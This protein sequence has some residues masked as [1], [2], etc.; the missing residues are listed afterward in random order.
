MGHDGKT[1][2]ERCKAKRGKLPGLAFAEKI[3]WR[4]RPV[5]GNLSKLTCLWE[6]GIFLGVKG[7]SGECIVGDGNGVWKTRT[8][9]R[10]PLEERWDKGALGLVG[11]VPWRVNDDDP[12]AD[13][14]AM[15]MDIPSE[16]RQATEQEREE[17]AQAPIPRNFYITKEHLTKYGDSQ[18][19]PGC[20][21]SLRVTTRQ[22]HNTACRRRFEREASDDPKVRSAIEK[23]NE[24][25]AKTLE[26]EDERRKRPRVADD[27][28][29]KL[30][31]ATPVTYGGSSG[32]GLT[33]SCRIPT[34]PSAETSWGGAKRV[35]S[36]ADAQESDEE[37]VGTDETSNRQKV[38]VMEAAL[39]VVGGECTE[40]TGGREELDPV[41]LSAGRKDEEGY[42]TEHEV[43]EETST[44][45]VDV[46]KTLDDGV[47]IVR[48]R[49][50]GRDFKMKGG[51]HPEQFLLRLLHG[52]PTSCC[53]R[54]RWS[55]PRKGSLKPS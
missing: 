12:K 10:R 38:Q 36:W 33:D 27:H 41:K 25:L 8:L 34:E 18:D 47:E 24:F 1:P 52:K 7:S 39:Q 16:A 21:S 4:R 26:E 35:V 20:K 54:C 32:S 40:F 51:G 55:I 17:M 9:T 30:P 15:K 50:V 43:F 13:G 3:L 44:R 49:L 6:D 42:L 5:G 31:L 19:C 46:K 11:G 48:S 14:E 45:W 29:S 2:Y 53:S 37:M 28:E 22:A 23:Q